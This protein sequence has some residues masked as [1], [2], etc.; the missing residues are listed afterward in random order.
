MTK[1]EAG[2]RRMAVR[3]LAEKYGVGTRAMYQML[4][5]DPEN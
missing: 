4:E 1:F 2:S 3:K 5:S